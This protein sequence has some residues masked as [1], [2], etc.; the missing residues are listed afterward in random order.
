MQVPLVNLATPATR[1]EA[2]GPDGEGREDRVQHGLGCTAF[3][4]GSHRHPEAVHLGAAAAR[5]Y[6]TTLHTSSTTTYRTT[7]LLV[8]KILNIVTRFFPTILK[9]P[10]SSLDLDNMYDLI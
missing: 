10:E 1:R 5:T 6:M 3:W 4:P 9:F 2:T 7:V 8:V